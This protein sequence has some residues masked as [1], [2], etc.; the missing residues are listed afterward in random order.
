MTYLLPLLALLLAG[1]F[2]AYHRTSLMTWAILSVAALAGAV[3]LDANLI[4]TAVALAVFALV[5]VP[6]LHTGLR[7]RK[8][9]AP[10]LKIYTRMLPQ[11]SDTEKTAL[12]A[13]TVGF[14]GELFSGM[15]K[16]KDL[17]AQP[18]PELT[19]AEQAFLDGPVEEVL[20]MTNDWDITHVR[21]DLPPEIWEF[22]GKDTSSSA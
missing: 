17:L 12:E 11:L 20:R 14:E 10:L 15:P 16:W 5:A 1:A 6:L 3:L 21:A 9:T 2:A 18:K 8:L 22:L 19:A 13:G 4:A 7:R